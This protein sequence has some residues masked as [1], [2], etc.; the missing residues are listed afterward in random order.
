VSVLTRYIEPKRPT[1]GAADAR[2][3][4]RELR[5]REESD[6][7]QVVAERERENARQRRDEQAQ[8]EAAMA[9]CV[10]ERN[11]ERD[12]LR[13]NLQH[14]QDALAS[15]GGIDLST[16]EGAIAS[17]DNAAR[18]L[19]GEYVVDRAQRALESWERSQVRR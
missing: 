2:R 8:R 17:L 11:A 3:R 4:L 6:R 5:E 10:R 12:R 1:Q 16:V 7:A 14:A 19:A 13:S 18:R 15:V 9:Q